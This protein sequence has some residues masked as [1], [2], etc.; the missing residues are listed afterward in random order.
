[1]AITILQHLNQEELEKSVHRSGKNLPLPSRTGQTHQTPNRSIKIHI[2]PA[3]TMHKQ[4]QLSGTGNNHFELA[5]T[6]MQHLNQSRNRKIN[7]LV[8]QEHITTILNRKEASN[9]LQRHKEPYK[10]WQ[11]Y[12]NLALT[13]LKWEDSSTTGHNHILASKSKQN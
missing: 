13:I 9:T 6:I 12:A 7:P 8:R 10:T 5:I 4:L 11:Y 2:N 3:T 1:M